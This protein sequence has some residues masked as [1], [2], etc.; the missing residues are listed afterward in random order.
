MISMLN[1]YPI[2]FIL[3][4][5]EKSEQTGFVKLKL[6]FLCIKD[7]LYGFRFNIRTVKSLKVLIRFS[8]VH[9]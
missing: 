8:G 9:L 5:P 1:G 7:F 2:V 3:C 4:N 6:N